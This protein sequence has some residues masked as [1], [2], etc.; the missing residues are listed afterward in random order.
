LVGI[1]AQLSGLHH[2]QPGIVAS[3]LA[4]GW[5]ARQ[6]LSF[7]PGNWASIER[8]PA[9]SG[10]DVPTPR[11][12][13]ETEVTPDM[14]LAGE[15]VFYGSVSSVDNFPGESAEVLTAVFRAMLSASRCGAE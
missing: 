6:V 9:L 14:I 11:E 2:N 13:E 10:N 4:R 15:R 5:R 8:R 1:I 7:S 12:A 3:R